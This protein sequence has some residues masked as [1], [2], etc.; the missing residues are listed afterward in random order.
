MRAILVLPCWVLYHK[1]RGMQIDLYKSLTT[2]PLFL[3]RIDKAFLAVKDA[4]LAVRQGKYRSDELLDKRIKELLEV[5]NWNLGILVPMYF[6][7]FIDG[8]PLNPMRRPHSF[9]MLSLFTYGYTAV[10][11]SRQIAKS[12]K[13]I[14]RQLIKAMIFSRHSSIYI[15]PHSE[16]KKTYANRFREMEMDC[17]YV[18]TQQS[19]GV[20]LRNNLFY[21]EYPNQ[22][23]TYIVNALTDTSQARSKSA[24]ELMYDEYQ[25]FDIDLEPDIEQ[26]QS[27][28]QI[29]MTIYAGTSTTI[30]S[31][32]EY[33]YQE[34][35]QAHWMVKSPNGTDWLDFGDEKQMLKMIRPEGLRCPFTNREI[36][37]TQGFYEHM[38]PS[39]LEYGHVSVHVPQLIIP[40]KV[41]DLLEWNKIY[42]AFTEYD[43][44]KFM[45][46]ILGIPTE[47]GSSEISAKDLQNIAILGTRQE[48][49]DTNLKNGYYR[50]IVSGCDWGGSDH[51][52][53]KRDK[54][55]YTVHAILGVTP[56]DKIDILH[57][58]QYTGWT[59]C[60]QLS[61]SSRTTS[62]TERAQWRRMRVWDRPTIHSWRWDWATVHIT[63]CT[64]RVISMI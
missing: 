7:T 8:H 43:P 32:L 49:I 64:I 18:R 48:L 59:S 58:K 50:M 57:I 60:R 20:K 56:D 1:V 54:L 46:E 22:S 37:V 13:L 55:S 9:M 31:P 47:E 19:G 45:E 5:C 4:E 34:G 23:H 25:L 24:D 29:P 61:P 62:S 14:A 15:C 28:S 42:K 40:D 12:T 53:E 11:G 52:K 30:D 6:P 39:R 10:R 16:H 27:V 17:P 38:F 2:D 63:V 36:D 41:K 44:K 26:C 21:K 51:I 3:R 33:R 35:S